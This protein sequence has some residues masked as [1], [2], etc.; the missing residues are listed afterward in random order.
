MTT[1]AILSVFEL[2]AVGVLENSSPETHF[3]HPW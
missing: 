2:K 3:E 1:P